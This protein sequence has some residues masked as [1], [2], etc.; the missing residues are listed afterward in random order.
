MKSAEPG[1]MA[2]LNINLPN[3]TSREFIEKLEKRVWEI[4]EPEL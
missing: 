4:F 1:G 3:I 2:N